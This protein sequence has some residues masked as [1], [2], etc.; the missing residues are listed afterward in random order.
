MS[1]PVFVLSKVWLTSSEASELLEGNNTKHNKISSVLYKV[2]A[3]YIFGL[4]YVSPTQL[5]L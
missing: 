2:H 1:I 3:P 4:L 5:R